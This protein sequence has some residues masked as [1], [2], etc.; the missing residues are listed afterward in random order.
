[1]KYCA[2]RFASK[3]PT[4][5]LLPCGSVAN[6]VTDSGIVR[7]EPFVQ[8]GL[9]DRDGAYPLHGGAKHAGLGGLAGVGK[10]SN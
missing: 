3:I 6:L 7:V 10:E 8:V 1:M 5:R 9:D 2:A 4:W